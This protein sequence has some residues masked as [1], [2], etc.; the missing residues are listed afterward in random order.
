M[1]SRWPAKSLD[2]KT[3]ALYQQC[4]ESFSDSDYVAKKSAKLATV[5][6]KQL[7]AEKNRNDKEIRDQG[8]SK[9]A[10][11]GK[12]FEFLMGEMLMMHGLAP[13]YAQVTLWKVPMSRMDFLL[14]DEDEPV[15]FTCKISL[16]ERWRQAAFEGLFLK[17]V[18]PKGKCYVVSA[19]KSDVDNRNAD[20][21]NGEI[22]GID[23]CLMID[24]K[25]LTDLLI[26]LSAKKFSTAEKIDPI[27]GK[28]TIIRPQSPVK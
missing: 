24:S 26:K 14:Y 2:S 16:A 17:N 8:Q 13:F 11:S 20:I 3:G 21:E 27:K 18:Y 23:Q 19:K 5:V 12:V 1:K 15:V 7:N 22:A 25:E 9:K 10:M 6:M 28:H 4:I